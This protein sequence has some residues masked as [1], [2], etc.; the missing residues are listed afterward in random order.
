[1]INLIPTAAKRSVTFEYW[2]RVVSVWMIILCFIIIIT[3]LLLLPV[4]VLLNSKIAAYAASAEEALDSVSEYEISS[5]ALIDASVQAGL[6]LDLTERENFS[7]LVK[8]IETLQNPGIAITSFVFTRTDTAL[9]PISLTGT[10]T[11]RQA[12]ADFRE[13]LLNNPRIEKVV[14]PISDLTQVRDIVFT[15]TVTMKSDI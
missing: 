2:M 8:E 4:Y 14:L 11:T 12:L 9:A 5:S 6:I 7:K 15:V 1:M 3:T 13:T 10:A